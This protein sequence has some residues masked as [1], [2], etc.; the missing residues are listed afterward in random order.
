M[1]SLYGGES[2]RRVAPV[3]QPSSKQTT[4]AAVKRLKQKEKKATPIPIVVQPKTPIAVTVTTDGNDDIRGVTDRSTDA[5][6]LFRDLARGDFRHDFGER[7]KTR[8][9]IVK[10]DENRFFDIAKQVSKKG[11]VWLRTQF[12]NK[13]VGGTLF[14]LFGNNIDTILPPVP[15]GVAP[16]QEFY[17]EV[18]L[19]EKL[20]IDFEGIKATALAKPEGDAWEQSFQTGGI[21]RKYTLRSANYRMGKRGEARYN[22]NQNIT[23][24]FKKITG[25]QKKFVLI[26]D[27]SGGLPLSD[28]LNSELQPAVEDGN[29]FYIIENIENTS[30]SATK[31]SG[32]KQRGRGVVPKVSFLRDTANTVVYPLWQNSGD[33]KSN[34]FSKMKIILNRITDDEVEADL[35]IVDANDKTI[36]AINIGDVSNSSNVKNA[37]L[38]ALA[39]FMEKGI[40]PETLA[41]TLIKRMGDWCQALSMLDLDRVYDILNT[42]R[43]PSGRKTKLRDMMVDSEIGVVTNDRILLGVCVLLGLNVFYTTA[44]DVAKVIYFKN[45]N[46]VPPGPELLKRT[47]QIFASLPKRIPLPYDFVKTLGE[48]VTR[49]VNEIELAEYIFQLKC[50]VSNVG[51]LRNE[52]DVYRS[53][54]SNSMNIYAIP[55]SSPTAKFNAANTLVSLYAKIVIDNKYN[56]NLV[57]DIARGVYK[58]SAQERIRIDALK[59]KLLTGGRIAKSVEVTEAKNILSSVRDDLLLIMGKKS[60]EL[61]AMLKPLLDVTRFVLPEGDRKKGNYDEI[62]SVLPAIR[63]VAPAVLQ[64]G[65]RQIG[66]DGEVETIQKALQTRSVRVIIPTEPGIEEST[67]TVNIYTTGG[68][69]ID[70]KLRRYTVSDQYIVT[71]GDEPVFDLFFGL[72]PPADTP[73]LQYICLKYLLLQLD[74]AKNELENIDEENT[75]PEEIPGSIEY[76]RYKDY[77]GRVLYIQSIVPGDIIEGGKILHTKIQSQEPATTDEIVVPSVEVRD[78]MIAALRG[79]LLAEIYKIA[80]LLSIEE[81]TET[82]NIENA[83]AD[84]TLRIGVFREEIAQEANSNLVLDAAKLQSL[85]EVIEAAVILEIRETAMDA[86]YTVEGDRV[87][88]PATIPD[89]IVNAINNWITTKNPSIRGVGSVK[90]VL[91]LAK[92]RATTIVNYLNNS[93]EPAAA[94]GPSNAA[95]GL[96]GGLRTRRPLYSNALPSSH[97]VDGASNHEGLRER[98][99]TRRTHRVRKSSRVTRRR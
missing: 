80:E 8:D 45:N 16:D 84:I 54:I 2:R 46:D 71:E 1:K 90:A 39:N 31:L 14:A 48:R 82:I 30:D 77:L 51:K 6:A 67:S 4:E 44:M 33:P 23:S 56:E 52:Y 35:L 68:Y 55:T 74:V 34:V 37:T 63:L 41:Y 60:P 47:D 25:G 49:V 29:E 9:L 42:D 85:G 69:Y 89:A 20:G 95:A 62:L 13:Y 97:H 15:T 50:L 94:A 64:G 28:I 65:G 91:D 75:E 7:E 57:E 10:A 70:E 76:E 79:D 5:W 73:G 27:A 58:D 26:V 83:F 66:G 88:L 96:D 3:Q 61:D 53:Q 93:L 36:Q 92:T 18:V 11:S 81:N 22:E 86:L 78:A 87:P 12:N 43:S 99:G 24:I 59:R 32:L 19:L 21:L 38:R 17:H 98:T 72:A 40:V